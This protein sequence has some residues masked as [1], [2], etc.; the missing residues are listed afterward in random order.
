MEPKR[1]VYLKM[2]TLEETQKIIHESFAVS[3]FLGIETIP[4]PEAAHRPDA[5]CMPE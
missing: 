2:K 3:D 4:V 5:P 1:N